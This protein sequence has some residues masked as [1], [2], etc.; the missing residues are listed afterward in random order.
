VI[1]GVE[2][3][4][5]SVTPRPVYL[6]PEQGRYAFTAIVPLVCLALAGALGFR[7]RVAVPLL[8]V[9]LVASIGLAVGARLL[10]VTATYT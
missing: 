4:Y 3:V 9:L 5:Y 7:R 6:I 1:G 8:S 2:F 10:Y